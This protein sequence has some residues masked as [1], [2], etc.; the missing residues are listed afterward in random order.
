LCTGARWKGSGRHCAT[1]SPRSEQVPEPS[2][3]RS[4]STVWKRM[5]SLVPVLDAIVQRGPDDPEALAWLWTPSGHHADAAP[6][7]RRRGRRGD[8][9]GA[10]GTGAG[11]WVVVFWSAVQRARYT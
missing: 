4:T 2:R 11:V 1:A 3:G 8:T 7:G 10:G 6:R 5:S 9:A